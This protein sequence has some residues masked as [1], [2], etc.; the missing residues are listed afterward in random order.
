MIVYTETLL[1]LYSRKDKRSKIEL[2]SE[3]SQI[4]I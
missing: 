2:D 1:M 3:T 4:K